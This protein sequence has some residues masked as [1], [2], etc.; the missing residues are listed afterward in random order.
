MAAMTGWLKKHADAPGH[1][2]AIVSRGGDREAYLE[3]YIVWM[4]RR[5]QATTTCSKGAE[6]VETQSKSY[7]WKSEHQIV[8][9]V[10]GQGQKNVEAKEQDLE[11]S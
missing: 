7:G 11:H 4:Q 3:R 10:Q 8:K 9:E 6:H 5:G 1:D 2:V